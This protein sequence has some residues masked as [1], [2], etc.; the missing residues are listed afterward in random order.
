MRT[1]FIVSGNGL[2]S[3]FWD[4]H[5]ESLDVDRICMFSSVEVCQANMKQDPVAV[6]VDDY[7]TPDKHQEEQFNSLLNTG[8][9]V[10]H[11]SPKH[12]ASNTDS[13]SLLKR[14]FS[15]ELID[16]VE[17]LLATA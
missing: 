6:I 2:K 15:T 10:I 3:E 9:A 7:F 16:D 8:T 17:R 12:A 11:L 5:F 1:L 4:K 13:G 14:N